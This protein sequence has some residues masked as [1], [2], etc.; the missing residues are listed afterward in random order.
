MSTSSWVLEKARLFTV[1]CSI[2]SNGV[3]LSIEQ[4]RNEPPNAVFMSF[5]VKSH[6][7]IT[8]LL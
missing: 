2:L 8:D 6:K 1:V 3:E 7:K 4:R 5:R